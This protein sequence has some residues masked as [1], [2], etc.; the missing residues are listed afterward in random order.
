MSAPI[1][2]AHPVR[3]AVRTALQD[4]WNRFDRMMEDTQLLGS[5]AEF[6]P[7]D[8]LKRA[9]SD[10]MKEGRKDVQVLRTRA[11]QASKVTLVPLSPAIA[12]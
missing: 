9:A 11:A 3:D 8:G 1:S 10:A 2:P 5:A 6:A 12:R 7:W 4:G